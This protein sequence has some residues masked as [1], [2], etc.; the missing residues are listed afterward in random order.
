MISWFQE[1]LKAAFFSGSS[2]GRKLIQFFFLRLEGEK[3]KKCWRL[4]VKLQ[5]QV[6]QL[7]AGCLFNPGDHKVTLKQQRKGKVEVS[8]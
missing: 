6:V 1:P 2:C 4:S 8:K 7:Q 5:T 3:D